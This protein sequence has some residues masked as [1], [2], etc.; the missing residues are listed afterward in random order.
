MHSVKGKARGKRGK[1]VRRQDV[2]NVSTPGN[3]ASSL[4]QCKQDR[5]VQLLL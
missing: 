5:D 1:G 3:W 2:G 4:S